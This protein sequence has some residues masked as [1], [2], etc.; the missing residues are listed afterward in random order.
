MG[1]ARVRTDSRGGDPAPVESP[2]SK[3]RLGLGLGLASL[4]VVFGDIGT[5]PLYAFQSIFQGAHPIPVMEHRVLGGV[6]LV[7]W[8]LTLVVSVKYVAVVMRADNDGE[9][10]VIALSALAARSAKASPR[11]STALA[12]LGILGAALFYGDGM[13][14]P[15]ISVLSAVEGLEVAS[16][17]LANWII[18]VAVFVLALLFLVQR[19]GSGKVGLAFG[20]IMLVWFAAIALIGLANIWQE[21]RALAAISP[22]Y[23]IDFFV[24]E[25]GLAFLALGAIVLCVTGA[26]ALYAD[27]GQFG[28]GPIRWSWY[29]IVT[30]ALYL[31]Y[32]GQAALVIRDPKAAANPFY[33]AVPATFQWPMV[34]LATVAT[35][36]ASQSVISGAFSMT[37][38]AVRLGYL[39]RLKITHTS[40]TERG[41][42]YA[43]GI[44]WAL[45][46]AVIGLVLAFRSSDN[47]AGAYGIAVTGTFVI[48]TV[49]I[50]YLAHKRWGLPRWVVLP[51]AGIFLVIDGSFFASN[52]MKFD[53]GGWFPIAVAAVIF[54]VLMSWRI[55]HNLVRK[56]LTELAPPLD[57]LVEEVESKEL[58]SIP[59]PMVYFAPH[60]GVTPTAL[61]RHMR[62]IGIV[63]RHTIIVNVAT[64]RKPR[65]SGVERITVSQPS[66]RL[67]FI[68]LRY[69]YLEHPDV[70]RDLS[71]SAL[72]RR[73]IQPEQATYV[74]HR[75]I[76][77]R[78]HGAGLWMPMQ[79]AFES[80][81][82]MTTDPSAE[83]RLPS[84]RVLLVGSVIRL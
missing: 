28:R 62:L 65:A 37:R 15:A 36:I 44:N 84:D 16:P 41:Q 11:V 83:L 47:L 61:V 23:A 76:V 30:P 4:G 66:E 8:T 17:E 64:L 5:S 60:L 27:M 53:H 80:M 13:I 67:T 51:F 38:Q 74:V 58:V 46:V 59:Q 24:G 29:L 43:P 31:T 63:S 81:Q 33:F 82:R 40:A 25:P 2:G 21:P 54:F 12:V 68:D 50:T 35:V 70:P 14:T 9:G 71:H 18:P 34:I 49:V 52:L 79:V 77:E 32:L 69:G 1:R 6:S 48:T 10:G 3:N 73:G 75:V 26:E 45:M 78:R 19:K 39:P 22:T 72:L 42:V 20:P 56:R 7:F 55:G 57:E